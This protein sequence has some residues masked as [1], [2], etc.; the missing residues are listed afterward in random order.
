M[1]NRLFRKKLSETG[2]D[3]CA[4]T[5]EQASCC[6]SNTF[7]ALNIQKIELKDALKNSVNFPKAI[8]VNSFLSTKDKLGAFL[9]RWGVKR[10]SYTVQPGLYS[11]G[12]PDKNSEVL[13]TANYKLTFDVLRNSLHNRSFWILVLDTKGINVWCAAGKGTFGTEELIKR[14]R[15]SDLDRLVSHRRIILPQL[16]APGVAAHIVKEQ[17]GFKAVYGPID[18]ANILAFTDNGLKADFSMRKKLF[19]LRERIVL[20]PIELVAAVKYAIFLFACFLVISGF[21]GPLNFIENLL[22]HGFLTGAALTA[23]VIAGAVLT[24]V[25]LPFLP[26]KAFSQKSLPLGVAAAIGVT[27][28]YGHGFGDLHSVMKT[29]AWLLMIPALTAFLAMNFT[30]ASTYTSLSGVKKEMKLWVPI[31]LSSAAAGLILWCSSWFFA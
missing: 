19:P 15:I 14:I 5:N 29:F 16:G 27:T 4:S 13:V 30:G 22:K 1:N 11:I 6:N 18:A 31:E 9:V 8:R 17:T 20:I 3:Y 26:G 23:S 25:L 28:L 10:M 24:P 2:I 12:D 21:L 7:S